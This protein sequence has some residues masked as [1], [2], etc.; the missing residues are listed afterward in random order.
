LDSEWRPT[1]VS[2]QAIIEKSLIKAL[3]EKLLT[4]VERFVSTPRMPT[5]LMLA[6]GK[7]FSQLNTKNANDFAELRFLILKDYLE[8]G[9]ILN[10]VYSNAASAVLSNQ[11]PGGLAS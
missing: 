2:L 11:N 4:N 9:A 8:V 10:A 3:A 5:P 1:F 6:N 7:T